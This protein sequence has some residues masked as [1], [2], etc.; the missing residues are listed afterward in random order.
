[1][2]KDSFRELLTRTMS[3]CDMSVIYRRYVNNAFLLFPSKHHI[4]RIRNYLNRQHKNIRFCSEIE[5]EN[6]ISFLDIK[7]NS[8]NNKFMTSV[9]CKPTF[10]RVLQTLEASSQ[11]HINTSCCLLYYTGHS[12]FAQVLNFF[13]R[14]LRS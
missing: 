13:I 8:E 1:M 11:S 5:N 12:N 9:Y 6:F 4:K 2:P 10:S 14:K 7:I 3:E